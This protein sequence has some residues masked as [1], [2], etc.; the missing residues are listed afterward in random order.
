M[1]HV[2]HPSRFRDSDP[3]IAAFPPIARGSSL[4]DP[5][6]SFIGREDDLAE[7][8]DLLLQRDTRLLTLTGPGGVGKTRLAAQ[9]VRAIQPA[10]DKVWFVSLSAVRDERLAPVVIAQSIGAPN[11]TG[12]N[13]T[14]RILDYLRHTP[15]L[16]VLDNLEHLLLI[17]PWLS[18]LLRECPGLT[19][20]CTSRSRLNL[21]AERV[22]PVPALPLPD[23]VRLF[24][25]RAKA[26]APAFRIDPGQ[27][28]LMADIQ[29]HL[30]G[31]PLAIELA[32]AR[33]SVISL[34]EL[35]DRLH[36]RILPT[37]AGGP[38]DVPQR[39][40]S[41][42]EV[43]SWSHELL[44]EPERRLFRRLAVFQ[45]GFTVATVEAMSGEGEPVLDTTV[46][47]VDSGLV[48]V[49][50]GQA[51]SS[52]LAI[53]EVIRE[54]AL[55]ELA[56]SGEENDARRAHARAYVQMAEAEIP[57]Y[58][59]PELR[60]AHDRIE[61]ELDNVR[62]ALAWAVDHGEAEI[63]IRLAGAMW[64][65]WWYGRVTGDRPWVERVREGLTW[66]DRALVH[67]EGLPV[68]VLT[69]AMTGAAH[70]ARMSDD[71]DHAQGLSEELLARSEAASYLYGTFWG[72]H[73]LGWLA[74]TRGEHEI[75]L[76][77]YGLA[78]T[79]ARSIR[80]PENHEAMTLIRMG[81]MA[82]RDGD[83]GEA[84]VRF[85]TAL[86]LYRVC[87]NPAGVA[88]AAFNLGRNQRRR[89]S[90]EQA[91]VLLTE[92][93]D[94]FLGQRDQGG[95]QACL[96]ELALAALSTNRPRLGVQL[97]HQA[98]ALLGHPDCLPTL[99]LAR[100]T[101]HARLGTHAFDRA[102]HEAR[103]VPFEAVR[104]DLKAWLSE[105]GGASPHL[106]RSA[107]VYGG[108]TRREIDVLTRLAEG[109]SNRA[110][111]EA[112][113]ISVRT[114]ENHVLHILEKLNLESRAAAAAWAV[115]NEAT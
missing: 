94:G 49:M 6:T 91:V 36:G 11:R 106:T 19:L 59:S 13:V 107:V 73:V 99:E 95:V 35:R 3:E 110:I 21:S 93:M 7:V 4:P 57:N 50:P 68:E 24:E 71:L 81:G 60:A 44:N 9:V 56:A 89:D 113:S 115:R 25:E 70:L 27:T 17:G 62:A 46:S 33:M 74:E 29:S 96:V 76:H 12:Q 51:D 20:L 32:A 34:R 111:G 85:G 22:Y 82:E 104:S 88:T 75:A 8:R 38:Q 45:G 5:F 30:D 102:R 23:A 15:A 72:H 39:H 84:A 87:G 78:R 67:R 28:D 52:R 61:A 2:T 100:S 69:E 108:L 92:A 90:T 1:A 79:L 101:A 66:L 37:L 65:V 109:K 42:R 80:N 54:Y 43:I 26:I 41:M 53:P 77:H 114:V 10:V 14:E 64:R 55:E 98:D 31:L 63:G 103:D 86:A 18:E 97:L 48:V 47:L 83:L 16:L 58:D 105:I 40:Q 112:L